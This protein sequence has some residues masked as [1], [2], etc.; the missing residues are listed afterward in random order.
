MAVTKKWPLSGFL[1]SHAITAEEGEGR[2]G[3]ETTFV[4]RMVIADVT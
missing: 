2:I 4:S 3:S 1:D